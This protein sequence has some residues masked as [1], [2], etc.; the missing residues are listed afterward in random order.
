VSSTPISV[1]INGGQSYLCIRGLKPTSSA[2]TLASAESIDPAIAI[3]IN[4]L[5]ASAS[6]AASTANTATACGNYGMIDKLG[7][8]T[9]YA[10]GHY[11]NTEVEGEMA[12]FTNWG[13]GFCIVFK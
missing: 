12:W 4:V 8:F 7:L 5:D 2:R 9:A 13:C 10:N 6:I 3:D 11:E 1:D